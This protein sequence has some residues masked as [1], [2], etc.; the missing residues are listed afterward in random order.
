MVVAIFQVELHLPES[1]S[2]KDK[3]RHIKSI[4]GKLKTSYNVCVTEIDHHDLRQRAALGIAFISVSDYQAKKLF[5]SIQ[6]D[7]ETR[8]GVEMIEKKASFHKIDQD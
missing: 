8:N 1:R 3:R 2:L 5:S 6:R 4:L 7:L